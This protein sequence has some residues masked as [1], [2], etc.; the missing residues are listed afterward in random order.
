M[1]LGIGRYA[2]GLTEE[3]VIRQRLRPQRIHFKPRRHSCG[4][5]QSPGFFDEIARDPERNDE[6]EKDRTH[7]QITPHALPPFRKSVAALCERRE[8]GGHRPP[9]QGNGYYL[10]CFVVTWA[11]QCSTARLPRS[12][13]RHR[14]SRCN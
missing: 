12:S 1:I 10:N 3:P 7:V 11:F 5:L 2:D 9:L 4:T 6:C 8:Y 14:P 13:L